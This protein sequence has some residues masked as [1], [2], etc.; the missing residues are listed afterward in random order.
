MWYIEDT[1]DKLKGLFIHND[2]FRYL[3]IIGFAASIFCILYYSGKEVGQLL[4][5]F[6]G[7][8]ITD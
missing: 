4:N 6:Y 2:F 5:D 3:V 1:I 7:N 8:R